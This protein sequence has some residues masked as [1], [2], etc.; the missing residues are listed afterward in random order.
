[1]RFIVE[2][3]RVKTRNYFRLVILAEARQDYRQNP[4]QPKNY[5]ASPQPLIPTALCENLAQCQGV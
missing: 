3:L 5:S 4:G 2:F 1:M